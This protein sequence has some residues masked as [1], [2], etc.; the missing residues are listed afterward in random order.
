ENVVNTVV[1]KPNATLA[2]G[3]FKLDIE[4][5][6]ARLKNNKDAHEVYIEKTIEYADTLCGFVE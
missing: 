5:I 6:S 1:S 4:P 3:M 2:P